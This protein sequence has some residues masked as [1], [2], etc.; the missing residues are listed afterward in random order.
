MKI[1]LFAYAV[2]LRHCLSKY[3]FTDGLITGDCI[4]HLHHRWLQILATSENGKSRSRKSCFLSR[5][6]KVKDS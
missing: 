3:D 6:Y 4:G 1:G 2:F 5:V